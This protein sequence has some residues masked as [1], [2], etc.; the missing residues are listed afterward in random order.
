MAIKTQASEQSVTEYI[1]AI[2]DDQ[3]KKDCKELLKIIKKV[4]GL[5][6][7]V[8]SNGTIGFG[9][10]HYKYPTGQEGD[11]YIT[12][13]AARKANITISIYATQ[14]PE[15]LKKLGKHKTGVGCLYINKLS[16]VDTKVLET[17]IDNSIKFC[18]KQFAAS[19]KK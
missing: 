12:G 8:W 17:M 13:F 1:D 5:K 15:L 2:K 19:K 4:S 16:D 18:K 14:Q 7:K 11:W 9:T 3:K 10:Y 6:P